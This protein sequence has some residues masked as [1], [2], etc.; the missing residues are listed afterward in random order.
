[1]K[2]V[3]TVLSYAGDYHP[4]SKGMC[5]LRVFSGEGGPRVLITD[6]GA[7]NNG[8]SVTNAI[9]MIVDRIEDSGLALGATIFI[10][11]YENPDPERDTFD[12]VRVSPSVNWHSISKEAAIALL[13]CDPDE[14]ED[15]TETNKRIV[16]RAETLRLS[17]SRFDASP[18]PES[19]EITKRK[20]EIAE[21]MISRS[22]VR[23]LVEAGSGERELQRLLKSDLS[24][25]A[26]A[27]AS[28]DGEY[29]CFSELPF[30]DGSVDF[31]VFT[32]RSRMD[33]ILIEVKGAE[34]NLVNVN[35]YQEF[36]HKVLE[37]AGQ[38]RKRL[39]L[40]CR[41]PEATRRELHRIRAEAERGSPLHNA[42]LGPNAPLEVDPDKDINIRS[43]IIGGRTQNVLQ[44]SRKRHDYERGTSPQVRL[45]SWDTWLRRIQ[46][47]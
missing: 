37:A 14:L 46:R 22:S 44:E 18:W 34:F 43:V 9:E 3:D 39:G 17:T 35:H 4:Q 47:D 6:L 29:I 33:I 5:R 23:A 25:I 19:P 38:L 32:G 30:G 8:R 11:H 28:P 31:A 15:R 13:G 42:F 40:F 16:G 26:E 12:Q 1:M 2:V 24:I 10:E 20:L 7:C 21:G 45:E 27:F 41:N 36:N